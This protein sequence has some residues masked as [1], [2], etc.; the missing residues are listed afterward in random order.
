M[1]DVGCRW[2]LDYVLCRSGTPDGPTASDS[3]IR[4][5]QPVQT[6]R[7]SSLSQVGKLELGS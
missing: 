7:Y 6:R 3:T 5:F 4:Y 2:R 1:I